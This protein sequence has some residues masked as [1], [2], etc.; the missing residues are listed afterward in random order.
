M[1][2]V[3]VLR[4]QA[5]L[6]ALDDNALHE[7]AVHVRPKCFRTGEAVTDWSDGDTPL[8]FVLSGRLQEVSLAEDGR[9]IGLGFVEAGEHHGE[10]AVI[11]GRPSGSCLI[12][13]AN[14]LVG[15]LEGRH[16]RRLFEQYPAVS[17]ALLHRLCF[18]VR[19]ASSS[20]AMLGLPSAQARIGAVLADLA[21]VAEDGM[22]IIE[23]LPPHRAIAIAANVSRESVCRYINAL[24]ERGD[25]RREGDRLILRQSYALPHVSARREGRAAGSA[26]GRLHSGWALP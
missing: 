24:L 2:S 17:Q 26:M 8:I 3:I 9:E 13:V 1:L 11:E 22:S 7:L 18:A 21:T 15:L 25:A 23:M 6:A 20:R 12:A 16:A 5:L 19:E 4:R 14:S 10:I